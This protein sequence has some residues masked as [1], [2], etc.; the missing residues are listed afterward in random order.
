MHAQHNTQ[1]DVEGKSVWS[2][3]LPSLAERLDL[4]G[5]GMH[6]ILLCI[7]Q[8]TSILVH[9]IYTGM[10][11]I[12]TTLHGLLLC[13]EH[14][15][16]M[17]GILLCIEQYTSIM[18]CMVYILVCM[19]YY[20]WAPLNCYTPI[21]RILTLHPMQSILSILCTVALPT[22]TQDDGNPLPNHQDHF[23]HTHIPHIYDI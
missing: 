22:H 8:Y 15:T 18:V 3:A 9:G 19:A 23:S 10:H 2:R 5:G 21:P 7:E 11:G 16:G 20:A 6:G 14:F 1:R 13:I 17:Q 4:G 12:Y